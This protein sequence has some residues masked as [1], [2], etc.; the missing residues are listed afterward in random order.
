MLCF[1]NRSRREPGLGLGRRL[2]QDTA[3]AR[4]DND[5]SCEGWREHGGEEDEGV[6]DAGGR[7]C[8][9]IHDGAGVRVSFVLGI[10]SWDLSGNWVL[11]RFT[12]ISTIACISAE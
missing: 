10:G 6:V 1:V 9:G 12:L 5:E 11:L 8:G 7:D 4:V 2:F 3:R